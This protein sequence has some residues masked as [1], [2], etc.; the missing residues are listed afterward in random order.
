MRRERRM[1]KIEDKEPKEKDM[2]IPQIRVSFSNAVYMMQPDKG[3]ENLGLKLS[4]ININTLEEEEVK[5]QSLKRRMKCCYSD[6]PY[7]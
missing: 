3:L 5:G 4:T 7:F 6:H 1:T 2:V